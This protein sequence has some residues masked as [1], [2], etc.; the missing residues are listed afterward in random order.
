MM[1]LQGVARITAYVFALAPTFRQPAQP[2]Q[3]ENMTDKVA[4]RRLRIKH[5]II[6]IT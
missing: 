4:M 2:R 1:L 6:S 5:P 3:R